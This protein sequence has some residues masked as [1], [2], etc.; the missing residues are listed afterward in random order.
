MGVVA[1][2]SVPYVR[3]EEERSPGTWGTVER[4]RI[5]KVPISNF[6]GPVQAGRY[7]SQTDLD[8]RSHRVLSDE[9]L[10]EVYLRCPDVRA[11]IDAI[12]RRVSTWDWFFEPTADPASPDYRLGEEDAKEA[13][14][15]FR[16]PNE[17]DE[18]IQVLLDKFT[19]DLLIW[20]HGVWELVFDTVI[21]EHKEHVVIDPMGTTIEQTVKIENRV[22][23]ELQEVVSLRGCS[24]HPVED[25]HGRILGY[26]QSSIRSGVS[27]QF[28]S[29]APE[30]DGTKFEKK[31]IL[32]QQLSSNS[33]RE[34][35][36]IIETVINEIIAVKLA[37]QHAMR[38]FNSEIP[39]GVLVLA[40]LQGKAAD[41]AK[42]EFK[43][44][45]G[46]GDRL[47]VMTNPDPSSKGATWVEFQHTAK[48]VDYVNVVK[49]T[50]RAIWRAFGVLPVEMGA[51]ED[52]P[53]AVGA[54]QL[55]VST[56]HLINPILE[57]LEQR[58][59]AQLVHLLPG[60]K[61]G[62]IRFRFDRETKL[63][64]SEQRARAEMIVS[65]V[66]EGLL[67]RN[68]GRE[69]LGKTPYGQ[70]GDIATVNTSGEP[71]PLHALVY[72][73][74]PNDEDPED[75]EDDPNGP[76]SGGGPR[77]EVEEP[78][79]GESARSMPSSWPKSEMF[80][81]V[82]T[83]DLETL[84][85]AVADYTRTVEPWY[86]EASSDIQTSI[87]AMYQEGAHTEERATQLRARVMNSID[88]LEAR[89]AAGTMTHYTR[90][91]RVARKAATDF[92]GA[93]VLSD[94]QASAETYHRDAMG[95][96]SSGLMQDLRSEMDHV[97]SSLDE[98]NDRAS[99]DSKKA[100]ALAAVAKA[101]SAAKHRIGNWSGRLVDLANDLLVRGLVE[102]GSAVGAS[103]LEAAEWWCEW[104]SVQDKST[105]SICSAEARS[106]FRPLTALSI[107]PGSGT[108]CGPKCRCVLV[109]WTRREID[110]GIA[111]RFN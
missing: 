21:V 107:H 62:R 42:D 95:F 99:G 87:Q 9:E 58:I 34:R 1:Y 35:A 3:R 50:R 82:R 47:H 84:G 111:Q 59:N 98:A 31:Q 4:D 104:V 93:P 75:P 71:R 39:P 5:G 65:L 89:W 18:P 49:E 78:D 80:A 13:T 57:L 56:S 36:P 26:H 85:D 19:K 69:E 108:E 54:V 52:I 70:A 29:S 51:S 40:G 102:S 24:I 22:G 68:E 46:R 91:A 43:K 15:F 17:D 73:I 10:W 83:I 110:D 16:N 28:Q 96:L 7:H 72:G 92:S 45:R 106:G 60:G 74:G 109:L 86:E 94:Y 27:F 105:C 33:S 67:T 61:N 6:F 53:R 64:P 66:R 8:V 81:S 32:A 48:D 90:A 79:S 97:L 11:P 25:E 14:E 38:S 30:T 101:W 41:E 37:S 63:T 20:D 88:R 77:T 76:P 103:G 12:S 100:A 44:Q 55:D 23:D 2:N